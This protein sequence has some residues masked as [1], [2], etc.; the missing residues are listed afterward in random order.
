MNFLKVQNLMQIANNPINVQAE[1]KQ[2]LKI[3][4][5]LVKVT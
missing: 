5:A 1:L 4:E 2:R 3:E